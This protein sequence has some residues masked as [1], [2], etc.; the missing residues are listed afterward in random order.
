MATRLTQIQDTT[1]NRASSATKPSGAMKPR[2]IYIDCTSTYLTGLNT[3]IQ[4]VVRGLVEREQALSEHIGVPCIPVIALKNRYW[5]FSQSQRLLVQDLLAQSAQARKAGRGKFVR[6]EQAVISLSDRLYVP[7]PI[8]EAPFRVTR[9]VLPRLFG[10]FQGVG[11]LWA[12]RRHRVRAIHPTSQDLLVVPD[13]FW[14][15]HGQLP[16]IEH[17]ADAGGAVV[18]VIHDILP[19]THPE[20]FPDFDSRLFAGGLARVLAKTSG[21]LAV[22]RT[23][24]GDIGRYCAEQGYGHLFLDFAY[25]GADMKAL[26]A[27]EKMDV[28]PDVSA[29]GREQPF[30]MVGTLEPRKDYSTALDAYALYRQ[31]GGKRSL[32]IV[33]RRGWKE[34]DI[35]ARIRAMASSSGCAFFYPDATDAELSFLYQNA[36]ALIFASRDEGFGLPLVEAMH[37]G[38]PVIASDIPVFQ[39]IGKDYPQYFHVGDAS[40]L[41]RVMQ[42]HDK[43]GA[44][45]KKPRRLWPTW[46]MA[47]Q[48][49]IEKAVT[50]YASSRISGAP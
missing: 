21:L 3:G 2:R 43:G 14:R 1:I 23:A 30:L 6:F 47:A 25:S 45:T 34:L 40:D 17:F 10:R 27:G 35:V 38:V 44:N 36:A 29:R 42:E 20:Y 37:Q 31:A 22:S 24:M 48:A 7:R 13:V 16:A 4:R 46:D 12:F 18:P 8:T 26:N 49:Y 15:E 11:P 41:C 32:V 9:H 39:E 33:G 19:L 50:L 5:P 28:R